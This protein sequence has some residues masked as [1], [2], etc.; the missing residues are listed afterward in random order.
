MPI[1]EWAA[2]IAKT[3]FK[4]S[5]FEAKIA[6]GQQQS[7]NGAPL[8]PGAS[9]IAVNQLLGSGTL[10]INKDSKIDIYR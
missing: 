10:V 5:T 6:I 8:E 2:N 4:S 7:T 1:P 9:Q 3:I